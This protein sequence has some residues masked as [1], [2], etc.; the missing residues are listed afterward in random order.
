MKPATTLAVLFLSLVAL[1]HLVRVV[2][3]VGVDIGG[4]AVPLWMSGAAFVL[5]A[6]LALALSREGRRG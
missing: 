3:R 4:V 6:L 5:C 1:A 2:F